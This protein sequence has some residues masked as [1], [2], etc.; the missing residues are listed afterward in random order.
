MKAI[1]A[2]SN[3]RRI[4]AVLLVG[5]S[6]GGLAV[7]ALAQ[8]AAAQSAPAAPAGAAPAPAGAAP[9]P[10]GVVRS[11][12]VVGNQR[13]EPETV[14][15]YMPVR[16]GE[17]YT[18][19]RLDEALRDLYATELFADVQIRDNQGSLTVEVRENPVIS[20]IVLDGNKRLK[21]DKIN[22]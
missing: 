10:A 21:E 1:T 11:I 14:I 5:T 18:R 2:F 3:G 6:L 15:S 4:C 20:R 12:A 7:P 16:I 19:E 17:T 13:L 8:G 9:A 22:P